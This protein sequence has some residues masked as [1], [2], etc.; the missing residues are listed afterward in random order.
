M[1]RY[2]LFSG[3][4]YYPSGGWKDFCGDYDSA[5]EAVQYLKEKCLKDYYM[6][7]SWYHVVDTQA[8]KEIVDAIFDGMCRD[9]RIVVSEDISEEKAKGWRQIECPF[10]NASGCI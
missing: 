2:L 9:N 6:S 4:H 5:E 8:P 7:G 3:D 1:K 10:P